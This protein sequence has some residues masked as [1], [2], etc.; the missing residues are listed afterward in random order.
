MGLVYNGYPGCPRYRREPP[1]FVKRM[2]PG[3]KR[4]RN[5]LLNV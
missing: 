5:E 2:A 1:P 4:I 3:E